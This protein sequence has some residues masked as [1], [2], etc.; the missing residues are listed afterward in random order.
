MLARLALFWRCVRY[1]PRR[2][3]LRRLYLD[4]SR[5]LVMSAV[6]KPWQVRRNQPLTLSEALPMRIFEPRREQVVCKS[7]NYYHRLL[8]REFALQ[9][10]VDWSLENVSDTTHLQRL[11]FHYHECL[12]SLPFEQGRDLVLDWIEQNPPWKPGYWKDSWNSYAISIRCVCWFQW[13]AEHRSQLEQK[14]LGTILGSLVEQ[15]R[16]LTGNLETDIC[17]NHLIKN[18]KCLLW[19][20]RC[21]NGAEA[22]RWFAMGRRLLERELRVQL[23]SDGMHFELSPAYHCQVFADLLECAHV[24]DEPEANTL[25]ERLRDAAQVIVDLTHP[26][27]FISLFGDGGLRMAYRP[28]RC[29]A[30]YESLGGEPVKAREHFA[31]REAGYFGMR[32]DRTYI[33]IDCGPPCANA[34]PAHGHGDILSFEWDVDGQRVIVDPGVYEY[35]AGERRSSDRSAHSHNT[36]AVAGRDQCEFVGSFRVGRRA[37]VELESY[38]ASA[39]QLSLIGSHDG[40]SI[41]GQRVLH[42][43]TFE[44]TAT[45]LRITDE[46]QGLPEVAKASFRLN[47][48]PV[49]QI[50][51]QEA[52]VVR[53]AA[54]GVRVEA[55][56]DLESQSVD[57]SRDFGEMNAGK[58]LTGGVCGGRVQVGISVE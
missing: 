26:D 50:N 58:Y 2:Q 33:V 44:V 24:L 43:R 42:R 9:L 27:G 6:G 32:T 48:P 30:A 29:L 38:D 7:G 45:R 3:L 49:A 35:E 55:D 23:L 51:D 16:F 56:T 40:F 52:G 57:I 5:R 14:E 36:V 21:F 12:E 13:L 39:G 1:V 37:K 4:V 28:D 11:A 31:F 18:I 20:G 19:A 41:P 17:G 54:V 46:I 34:L 25:V 53:L 10:P 22:R 15:V 47:L 8:N